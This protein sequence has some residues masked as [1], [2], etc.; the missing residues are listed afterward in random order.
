MTGFGCQR[1]STLAA[2]ALRKALL[3]WLEEYQ[4]RY[5]QMEKEKE[6]RLFREVSPRLLDTATGALAVPGSF[7]D[8]RG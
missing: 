8:S 2:Y 6:Q 1:L 7:T 5:E 4:E 3:A